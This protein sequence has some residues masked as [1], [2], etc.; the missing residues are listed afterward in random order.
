MSLLTDNQ[1][2]I[3]RFRQGFQV[4]YMDA[5]VFW[6]NVSQLLKNKK[7]SQESLCDRIGI[8]VW[9][10]RGAISKHTLPRVDVAQAI[11]EALDSSVEFLLKGTESN[12][13]KIRL[14]NLKAAVYKILD[15]EDK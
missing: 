13:Y 11:A 15:Q 1:E 7:I 4:F 3:C 14:D 2:Y 6:K 9:T 5:D 12:T 8:S 10:L